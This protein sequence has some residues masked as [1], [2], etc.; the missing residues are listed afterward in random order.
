MSLR[1]VAHRSVVG[2]G[3]LGFFE[4]LQSQFWMLAASARSNPHLFDW[5][6]ARGRRKGISGVTRAMIKA[7][8]DA[9]DAASHLKSARGA[10]RS[11][12]EN[13]ARPGT[14]H[15]IVL[16]QWK[17]SY[18]HRLAAASAVMPAL[19]SR[20]GQTRCGQ[21]DNIEFRR[22]ALMFHA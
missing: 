20:Q 19:A 18:R 17:N 2:A 11:K 8:P 16:T 7:R 3:S 14:A 4:A 9:N 5:Q 13:L 10:P 21:N 6:G 12:N 1:R 22:A 15:I